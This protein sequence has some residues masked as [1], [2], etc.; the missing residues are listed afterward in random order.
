[1]Q[2]AGV[3]LGV[4]SDSLFKHW[5]CVCEISLTAGRGFQS[6]ALVL[7]TVHRAVEGQIHT[8][9]P[10]KL[11]SSWFERTACKDFCRVGSFRNDSLSYKKYI[12]FGSC[13]MEFLVAS[14]ASCVFL[15][16]TAT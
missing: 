13:I 16:V 14:V 15:S 5:S 9:Y 3:S 11:R 6:S 2:L 1:M 8:P 12:V 10:R 7:V 4:V